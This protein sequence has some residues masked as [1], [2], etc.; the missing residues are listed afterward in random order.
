MG[1]LVVE[2]LRPYQISIMELFSEKSYRLVIHLLIDICRTWK[3]F[4]TF[5]MIK[6]WKVKWEYWDKNLL[7]CDSVLVPFCAYVPIICLYFII[8]GSIKRNRNVGTPPP[9]VK[10]LYFDSVIDQNSELCNVLIITSNLNLNLTAHWL[11]LSV[12]VMW[13]ISITH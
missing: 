2:R 9:L 1:T 5:F 7:L 13:V 11:H 10:V 3:D 4:C 6:R 8:L 12:S